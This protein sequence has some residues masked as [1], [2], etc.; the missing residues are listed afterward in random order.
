MKR[1]LRTVIFLFI[2]F[3]SGITIFLNCYQDFDPV[4]VA[5]GLKNA[6]KRDQAIDVI[7]FAM[8]HNIGD[9]E[10]LKSLEEEYQ[11]SYKEKSKD[12]F[13]HGAVKGEVFNMHSGIGCI[14]ADLAVI[15]DVRDLSKQGF[16]WFEG[17]DV[18]PVVTALS[19]IGIGTTIITIPGSGMVVDAGVSAVKTTAKYSKKIFKSAPDG[20]IKTAVAGKKFSAGD[21]KK[22]WWLFKE[23]KF[24][25]PDVA[26]VSSKI[27][28][29]NNIDTAIDLTK[30]LKKGGV[31]FLGRT[32]E[33][34]L[35]AYKNYS[36]SGLGELFVRAFK[37]NPK[38]VLGIT[39]LHTVIHSF[40]IF[41][42]QGLLLTSTILSSSLA[43]ILTML[44]FWVPLA[45]LTVSG[46]YLYWII[47]GKQK[48]KRIIRRKK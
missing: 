36:K 23:T 22:F 47:C 19:A 32:G 42:K 28:N 33:S 37:K 45:T 24:S 16:N 25:I 6:G 11:Y 15:G 38:A 30:N 44:P 46:G 18:D 29:V 35:E 13:W 21:Y 9:Q 4:E 34:G 39:R 48:D 31:I 17:K 26:L 2:F 27:K 41:R 5:V 1:I 20:I 8:D 14:A 10:T 43:L 12:L 7:E 3:S 40:K